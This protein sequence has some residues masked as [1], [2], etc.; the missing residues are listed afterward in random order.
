[1]KQPDT[2]ALRERLDNYTP[3]QELE[4]DMQ[5]LKELL[6]EIDDQKVALRN[7]LKGIDALKEELH[8]VHGSL[9]RT[10]QR[11]RT[12]FNAL[13]AAKDSA[14]NIVNGINNAIVKAEQNTVIP[15]KISTD[16][17]AKV[18]QCSTNH[19]KAEEE[20]LENHRTKLA[21]HLRNSEGIWLSN[22]WLTILLFVYGFCIFVIILWSYYR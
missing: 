4:E 5:D 16:E 1:M 3:E 12:A 7:L 20:L 15:A 6:Q 22:R 10:A 2:S 21:K 9:M 8:A 17:L 13:N 18:N 19:I 11:E 14:D